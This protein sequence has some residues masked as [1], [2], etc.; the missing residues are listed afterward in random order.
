MTDKDKKTDTMESQ[1]SNPENLDRNQEETSEESPETETIEGVQMDGET[2][3]QKDD[4]SIKGFFKKNSKKTEAKIK[5]LEDEVTA[6]KERALR[7]SADFDNYKKRSSKE[8][9]DFKKFANESLIK[10][11]LPVV[12]NL[13]RAIESGKDEGAGASVTEGVKMTLKELFKL[14]ETFNVK[15]V[16]AKGKPF[17]PAFHQAIT[18]EVS[19][20]YPENTVLAELQK[21]YLLHDRLIRPSMVIVSKAAE[22]K[23]CNENENSNSSDQNDKN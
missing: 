11:L 18:Q 21:G 5:A 2:T 17:D 19:S 3:E 16:E 6:G 14:F 15:P 12:D 23:S 13:E 8:M 9:A 20:E 10:K 7:L 1:H 22:N 4:S